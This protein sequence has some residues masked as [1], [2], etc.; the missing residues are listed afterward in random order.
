MIEV[1]RDTGAA[2]AP[3]D[4]SDLVVDGRRVQFGV[5]LKDAEDVLRLRDMKSALSA[6]HAVVG[7]FRREHGFST[8]DGQSGNP[9]YFRIVADYCSRYEEGMPQPA[10]DKVSDPAFYS[11]LRWGNRMRKNFPP[12][13]SEQLSVVCREIRA[14]FYWLSTLDS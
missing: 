12:L 8:E 13:T 11:V 9:E 6:V 1:I 2:Y 4:I 3:G 5:P 7:K 10:I 14:A